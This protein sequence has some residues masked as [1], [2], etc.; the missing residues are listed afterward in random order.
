[1]GERFK[2]MINYIFIVHRGTMALRHFLPKN[3]KRLLASR[4]AAFFYVFLFSSVERD[5]IIITYRMKRV[6]V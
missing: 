4:L 2:I 3:R 6:I 5:G 1:M